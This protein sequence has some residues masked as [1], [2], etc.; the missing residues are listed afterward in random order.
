[1]S[2]YVSTATFLFAPLSWMGPR[3]SSAET[4]VCHRSYI[5]A[6]RLTI[7]S[8]YDWCSVFVKRGMLLTVHVQVDLAKR[9]W[10]EDQLISRWAWQRPF[11]TAGALRGNLALGG[12]I[13]TRTIIRRLH[14]H[15]SYWY[16]VQYQDR[17]TALGS[18]YGP[19]EMILPEPEVEC[20]SVS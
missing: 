17:Q 16:R 13:G 5:I 8:L 3:C 12:H 20:F 10:E 2:F 15:N 6:A 9:H 4:Q 11:S 1:M 18:W 19:V 7:P 14:H